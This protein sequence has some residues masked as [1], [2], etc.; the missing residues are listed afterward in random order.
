MPNT[1]ILYVM[2]RGIGDAIQSLQ[3][4]HFLLDRRNTNGIADVKVAAPA[5]M[6]SFF[7]SLDVAVNTWI[8]LEDP[9]QIETAVKE[10]DCIID[11]SGQLLAG[12]DLLRW[13]LEGPLCQDRCRVHFS[14]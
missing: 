11:C 10:V 9:N 3:G 5:T 1:H 8:S 6:L 2:P 7:R 13:L 14:L 4:L 12:V